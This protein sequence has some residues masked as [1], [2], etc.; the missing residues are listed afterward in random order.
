MTDLLT[1]YHEA[2][3]ATREA[4]RRWYA[5]AEREARELSRVAAPGVGPVACAGILAALSPRAQWSVNVRW[6]RE[7]VGASFK[8]E[9]PA[10][11]LRGAQFCPAVSLPDARDKAWRIAHRQRPDA[12]L[13]GPKVRAFWRAIAG[14]P[15]A[16]VLDVWMLRAMGVEGTIS[17]KRYTELEAALR[18]AAS[19][20]NETV[21][22]FQAIVW[23]QI[24]GVKPTDPTGFRPV[25]EI[26]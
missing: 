2:D 14:D 13:R 19:T 4:G 15:D 9:D 5:N 26:G 6:A 7:I 21:R 1:F 22:D 25:G 12:V 20:T 11:A 10:D 24:R 18:Q 16:A 3:D 8:R 17:P 23:M